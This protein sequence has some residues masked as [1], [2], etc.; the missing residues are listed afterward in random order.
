MPE[1]EEPIDR[2]PD[3]LPEPQFYDDDD[4]DDLA[5]PEPAPG[6]DEEDGEA[7]LADRS[8]PHAT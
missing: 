5:D 4:D 3:Y 8:G 6:D 1:T 2:H 7:A